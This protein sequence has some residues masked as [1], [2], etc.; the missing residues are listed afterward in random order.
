MYD[1]TDRQR[2]AAAAGYLLFS[3]LAMDYLQLLDEL[4]L[5][6]VYSVLYKVTRPF[7]SLWKVKIGI[8]M[9]RK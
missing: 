9:T 4:Q 1:G 8:V 2:Q 5:Q 6:I 7:E 3:A